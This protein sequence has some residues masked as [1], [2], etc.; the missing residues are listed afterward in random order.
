[1]E[2]S[3]LIFTANIIGSK[4]A[5]I[6]LGA[7]FRK[8]ILRISAIINVLHTRHISLFHVSMI[9]S[10]TAWSTIVITIDTESTLAS[11]VYHE[12]SLGFHHEV[13]Y[14]HS[15]CE[16]NELKQNGCL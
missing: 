11:L 1:M 3:K 15:L 5:K 13:A 4:E 9:E 14:G 2:S 10:F 6:R 7:A 8:A 16:Q 12:K